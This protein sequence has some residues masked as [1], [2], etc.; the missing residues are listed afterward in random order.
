MKTITRIITLLLILYIIVVAVDITATHPQITP[1]TTEWGELLLG[2]MV[3]DLRWA[4][5]YLAEW[6]QTWS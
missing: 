2:K 6:Q 1:V 4:L 3:E 5:S